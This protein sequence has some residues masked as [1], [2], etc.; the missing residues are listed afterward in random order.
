MVLSENQVK[1]GQI[2]GIYVIPLV[3]YVH[4]VQLKLVALLLNLMFQYM[5]VVVLSEYLVQQRRSGLH[6]I[7]LKDT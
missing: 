5:L 2:M 1:K 4:L 3:T 6:H 7:T